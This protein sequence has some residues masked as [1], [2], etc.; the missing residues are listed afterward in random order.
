MIQKHIRLGSFE[1]K[2]GRFSDKYFDIK[3]PFCNGSFA[4]YVAKSIELSDDIKYI[5]GEEYGAIPFAVALSVTHNYLPY[6]VIR[7]MTKTHGLGGKVVSYRNPMVGKCC[8]LDDVITT[9][10]SVDNCIDVL[11]DEGH[12]LKV[13][14]IICIVDRTQGEYKKYP[15]HSFFKEED[16]G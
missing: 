2:S 3:T 14:S 11:K 6:F 5:G 12:K 10:T 13:D 4:F 16:F 1:L 9:G 8:I 7:K 15:I